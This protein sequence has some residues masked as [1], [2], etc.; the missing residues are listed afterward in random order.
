MFRLA[1]TSREIIRAVPRVTI[2]YRALRSCKS[3]ATAWL[4][5]LSEGSPR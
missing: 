3:L 1:L 5:R 4:A 2:Y